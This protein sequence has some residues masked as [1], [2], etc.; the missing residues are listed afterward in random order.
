MSIGPPHPPADC[1][2][3]YVASHSARY[4]DV[5]RDLIERKSYCYWQ[6]VHSLVVIHSIGGPRPPEGQGEQMHFKEWVP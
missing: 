2:G 5:V 6:A 1:H 4:Y 3:S